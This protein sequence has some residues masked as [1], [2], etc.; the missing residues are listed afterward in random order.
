MENTSLSLSVICYTAAKT[1]IGPK[2]N[3]SEE[4]S[5][6]IAVAVVRNPNQ[7]HNWDH[8]LG[9]LPASVLRGSPL[10]GN[11]MVL[12]QHAPSQTLHSNNVA[13]NDIVYYVT[14][15]ANTERW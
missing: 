7:Q 15:S 6:N 2:T 11:C 1:S 10:I 5:N 9:L 12:S 14:Y 4:K 3:Y 13:L 8:I